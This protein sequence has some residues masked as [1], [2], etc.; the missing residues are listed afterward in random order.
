MGAANIVRITASLFGAGRG[1]ILDASRPLQAPGWSGAAAMNRKT[2]FTDAAATWDQRFQGEDYLFGREP[3][4]YLA[5][6]AARLPS[7]GRALC[8]ADGEGRNSVWLARQGLQV[9]AFDIS[10]VGV[11]KARRLAAEAGVPVEHAVADCEQ[12]PWRAAAYNL[13]VAICIQ[14]ADPEQRSRLFAHMRDAV[15]PGG[16]IVLQGYTPKQLEYRTGGPGE[17]SH[18]YTE[19]LLRAEFAGWKL[20]DLR[21]YDAELHEGSRHRGPSALVGMVAQK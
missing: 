6:Q 15:V 1:A 9:E 18:L 3:N 5:A 13:V 2:A 7:R 17:L 12:W 20:L 16:L 14:F 11:A 4:D 19:D 21:S 8:V 10:A